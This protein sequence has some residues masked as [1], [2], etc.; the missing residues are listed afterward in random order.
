MLTLFIAP[1]FKGTNRQFGKVLIF[2]LFTDCLI[3]LTSF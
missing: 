2:T 3:I 1:N